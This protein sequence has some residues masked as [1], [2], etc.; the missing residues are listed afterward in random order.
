MY[1]MMTVTSRPLGWSLLARK[2][3]LFPC[4]C[5]FNDKVKIT[6]DKCIIYTHMHISYISSSCRTACY[7]AE[8]FI[9]LL[10][11]LVNPWKLTI[12]GFRFPSSNR[13]LPLRTT[14]FFRWRWNPTETVMPWCWVPPPQRAA[15]SGR[16]KAN[17]RGGWIVVAVS[18]KRRCVR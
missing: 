10:Q 13:F 8:T 6:K 3:S 2:R 1:W 17:A 4:A 12:N 9:H 15:E 7:L 14:S 5:I 11:C 18:F 16:R